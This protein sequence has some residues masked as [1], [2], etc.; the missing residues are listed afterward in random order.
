MSTNV[1]IKAAV[2]DLPA[3][4]K[5]VERISDAPGEEIYQEDTFCAVPHGRLKLRVFSPERGELIYYERSDTLAPKPSHYL[6]S[7]TSDPASLHAV[8]TAS[9]GIIGQVR[10]HRTLFMVGNTRVHLDEV[11]NLGTYMELEVVLNAGESTDNGEETAQALMDEL[12]ID[13]SDLVKRAYVDLL[14]AAKQGGDQ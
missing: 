13:P 1:E 12:R 4:R 8:L 7:T 11:E 14:N 10:K 5:R 3:L 2:A 6:I 9:L